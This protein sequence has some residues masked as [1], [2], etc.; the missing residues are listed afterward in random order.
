VLRAARWKYSTQKLRKNRHLGT[1]PQ[2]CRTISSQLH[3]ST[4][5]KNLLSSDTSSTCPHRMVNFGPQ[6][7]E[8]ISLVWGTPAN[9]NRF[10]FLAALLHDTVVEGV[11]Q[12][13]RR[14]TEGATC[15]RQGGHHVGHWPTFPVLKLSHKHTQQRICSKFSLKMLQ[16]LRCLATVPYDLSVITIPVSNCRLFSAINISEGS[17]AT[18]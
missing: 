4:I 8:I 15:I 13:L 14:W 3:V 12:T 10:C 2:F 16:Y 9:F 17:V 7:A 18:H 6:A 11:S 5:G 1:I